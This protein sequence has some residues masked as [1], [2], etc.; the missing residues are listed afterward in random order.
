MGCEYA[1]HFSFAIILSL[2]FSADP[3]L[4]KLSLLTNH[5][6][7]LSATEKID[8]LGGSEHMTLPF[9]IT[10]DIFSKH[11]LDRKGMD[12]MNASDSSTFHFILKINLRR[13]NN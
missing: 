10:S 7:P 8:G 5:L 12:D 6:F 13:G 11:I 2:S 9:V 4:E 3:I 1:S